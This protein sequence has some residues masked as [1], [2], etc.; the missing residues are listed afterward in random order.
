M[1]RVAVSGRAAVSSRSSVSS[2][3]PRLIQLVDTRTYGAFASPFTISL[4]PVAENGMLAVM[5][6]SNQVALING[7]ATAGW[8]SD[9]NSGLWYKWLVDGEPNTTLTFSGSADQRAAVVFL[10]HVNRNNPVHA[11]SNRTVFSGS[12]VPGTALTPTV[13]NTFLLSFLQLNQ[14]VAGA[15]VGSPPSGLYKSARYPGN[16]PGGFRNLAFGWSNGP[17][18]SVSTGSCT[19]TLP[20]V[21]TSTGI[22]RLLLLNPQ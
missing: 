5:G 10:R 14:G 21:V 18:A 22:N 4:S 9:T 17:A 2:R 19:W 6:F 13:A 20:Q 12:T 8:T 1:S 11:S 16:S 7:P 15:S 3:T